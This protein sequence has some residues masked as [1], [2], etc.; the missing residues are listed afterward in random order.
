VLGSSG[1]KARTQSSAQ[2][3]GRIFRL[4]QLNVCAVDLWIASTRAAAQLRP[5]KNG[6]RDWDVEPGVVRDQ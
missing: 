5:E 4:R 6:F 1:S 3:D 2:F